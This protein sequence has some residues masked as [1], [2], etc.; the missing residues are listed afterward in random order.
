MAT[1]CSWTASR[2]P[3]SEAAWSSGTSRRWLSASPARS[4]VVESVDVRPFSDYPFSVWSPADHA[5]SQQPIGAPFP[6]FNKR[7]SARSSRAVGVRAARRPGRAATTL[8]RTSPPTTMITTEVTGTDGDGTASISLA[9]RL[10]RNR[11][12]MIPRGTPTTVP[13]PNDSPDTNGNARLPSNNGRIVYY[14]RRRT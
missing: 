13:I 3:G 11:P 5:D 8:A 6:I 4:P 14:E 2:D 1:G 7:H 12:R 10:H 9:K